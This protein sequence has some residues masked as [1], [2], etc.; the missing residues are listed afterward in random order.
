MGS[1][2]KEQ[3]DEIEELKQEVNAREEKVHQGE[4]V[5]GWVK[6]MVEAGEIEI[7]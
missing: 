1:K 2:V 4:F 7:D 5:I 6:E 3:Y